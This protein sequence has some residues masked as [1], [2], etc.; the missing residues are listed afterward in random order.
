MES[1]PCNLCGSEAAHAV[2]SQTDIVHGSTNELFKVVACKD[3]GL[4]YTNP[5]PDAETIGKYY[6]ESYSFHKSRTK[7]SLWI[8]KILSKMANSLFW[9]IL[10]NNIPK[11]SR[12]LILRI[13]K[14][15]DDPVYRFLKKKTTSAYS[16]KFLDI[17]CGSGLSAHYFGMK[18]SLKSYSKHYDV[19]GVETSES[20]LKKLMQNIPAWKNLDEVPKDQFFDC[21]RMNW[22]LEH[23]HDPQKYFK[24]IYDHLR[25]GGMGVVCV[26]NMNGIL[27]RLFPDCLELPVHL[28][29]FR[30]E[31]LK[32]YIKLNNLELE[33]IETFSYPAMFLNSAECYPKLSSFRKMSLLEAFYFNRSLMRLSKNSDNGNDLIVTFKKSIPNKLN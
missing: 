33:S 22:S 30:P 20:A 28:Y 14:K 3:C 26:P 13:R 7:I 18:G 25:P 2:A 29:H 23:V 32:A 15:I 17:G 16:P 31:D 12:S 8:E 4:A 1:V 6:I 5:R 10:F 19:A 11:I 24:F 27:Y 9:A 21:I